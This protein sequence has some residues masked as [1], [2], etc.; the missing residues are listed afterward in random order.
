MDILPFPA[1][2]HLVPQLQNRA[3]VPFGPQLYPMQINRAGSAV[4]TQMFLT[5]A[6][7]GMSSGTAVELGRP[8]GMPGMC[9][10][11]GFA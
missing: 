8:A 3:P 5:G 10:W 4:K 2:P 7:W 6:E 9:S 11:T 1:G